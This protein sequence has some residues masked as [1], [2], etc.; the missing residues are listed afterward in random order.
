VSDYLL[1][2]HH[3]APSGHAKVAD[4]VGRWLAAREG[5]EY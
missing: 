2:D 4:A 1:Y 5:W 3:Y